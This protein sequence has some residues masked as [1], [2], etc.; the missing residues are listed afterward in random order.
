MESLAYLTIGVQVIFLLLSSLSLTF[1]PPLPLS[2]PFSPLPPFPSL[3][4]EAGMRRFRG[5]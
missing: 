1:H 3:H 2:L 5:T 4:R